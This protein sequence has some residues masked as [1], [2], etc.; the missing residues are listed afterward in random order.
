ME[1]YYDSNVV[2]LTLLGIAFAQY[3]DAFKKYHKLS[4]AILK[5]FGFGVKRVS[6]TRILEEI[7]SMNDEIMKQNGRPFYPK[8]LL[9][10]STS[11]F[12]LGI[13]FGKNFLRSY[14]KYHSTI[15]ES[16]VVCIANMDMTLNMAPIVRFLPM[17][18]KTIDRLRSSSE[19]MLNGLEEGIKFNKSNSSEATFVGRFLEIERTAYNHQDLL[20]IVRDLVFG[21]TDTVSTMLMW[22]MIELANHPDIQSR[23]QKEIDEMVPGDRLPSLD[24]KRR[25]P[26]TEAVILEIMRRH[27]VLPFFLTRAALKDTKV[28]GY[29]VPKQCMVS[30]D[31][32][33]LV[34]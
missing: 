1:I 16:S 23:F 6:E 27:T 11:N 31:W 13:L 15:V 3:N 30:I 25:L 17:F 21:S 26:Y 12:M 14:P 24:D 34:W 8:R 28:L 5:E 18:W 32:C 4:L 10:F 33:V 7:E 29:D 20:Y 19:R 22:A 2:L 9:S